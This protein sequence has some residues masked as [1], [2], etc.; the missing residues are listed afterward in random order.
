MKKITILFLV[1]LLLV[2][3]GKIYAHKHHD[4]ASMKMTTSDSLMQTKMKAHQEME[5]VTAFPNYHPLI[6]HFPIVLLLMAVVFQL[7]SFFYFKREFS[8]VTLILLAL[9]VI[10][11]W[12]ASNTFHAMPG[13]LSGRAKEIFTIHEQMASL[14]WW[15]SLI[16]LLLKIPSHFYFRQKWWTEAA[17]TVLLI[18]SAVTVSIAGHHGAMLVYMQGIGPQGKYLEAY[19]YPDQ[20][21]KAHDEN[22][23]TYQCP[24][25]PEVTSDKPETCPKC[26]MDL[27]PIK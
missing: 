3:I 7:I 10:T 18:T 11:A 27:I 8:I 15:F 17:V 6:V 4:S 24:M 2:S 9:G 13:E 5:A 26:G 1:L 23:L 14:T 22:V 19:H 25:H 20:N 16:A 21:K 12:L